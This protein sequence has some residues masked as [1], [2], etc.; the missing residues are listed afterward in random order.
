MK[1]TEFKNKCE[2]L[3]R[4][5]RKRLC[6]FPHCAASLP[7]HLNPWRRGGGRS[8]LLFS[9]FLLKSLILVVCVVFGK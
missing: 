9:V 8:V 6:L 7:H 2:K 5:L 3:K 4:F 1:P